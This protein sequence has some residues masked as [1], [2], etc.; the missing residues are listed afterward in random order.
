MSEYRGPQGYS[1]YLLWE[2]YEP[3]IYDP[4]D[5]RPPVLIGVYSTQD[6]AIDAASG[7]ML[8]AYHITK[9]YVG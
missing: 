6:R 4:D 3:F 2:D 8:D 9:E 7:R 1:V 5:Y